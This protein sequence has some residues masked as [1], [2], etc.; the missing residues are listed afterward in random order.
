MWERA[1]C[2]RIGSCEVPENRNARSKAVREKD[3]KRRDRER[4]KKEPE[5]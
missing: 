2:P 1:S 3:E 5:K 4:R